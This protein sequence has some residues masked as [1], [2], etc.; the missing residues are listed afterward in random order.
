MNFGERHDSAAARFTVPNETSIVTEPFDGH[1]RR[2]IVNKPRA[3]K[4]L[5]VASKLLFAGV[6]LERVA[7]LTPKSPLLGGC[8]PTVGDADQHEG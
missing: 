1:A 4:L 2:G 6:T 8:W 7:R 5:L 3:S